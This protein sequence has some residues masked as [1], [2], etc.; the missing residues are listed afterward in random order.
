[1]QIKEEGAQ[2]SGEIEGN[3]TVKIY[4]P[5]AVGEKSRRNSTCVLH[6]KLQ[7]ISTPPRSL[8]ILWDQFHSIKYPPG[9]IPIDSF[10]V[11]ND[12][13]DWHGDHL[14][15]NFHS[16]FD[17]LRGAGYYIET[18][19]S[20]LTCFDANQYGTLL[21][22]DLEDEYFPEEI[23]KLRD[24]VINSGL[25]LAVFA[26]WYNLDAMVKMRFFDGNSHNW[27][28][29]VTG[30]ANVPALNDLLAT[31]GIAFGDK[32]LSGAFV[33]SSKQNRYASGT[34]ILEFP[35]GGYLHSFPFLD[36]LQSTATQ[37]V[38]LP[39]MAKVS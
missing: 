22:V 15:T 28:I 12:L 18:L 23:K 19:G 1:M 14:H 24:D 5:S 4:S 16:L 11:R 30:G 17:M 3:I 33:F 32:I 37:N 26:D 39:G 10:D 29:P 21:L 9:Y 25:G 2:F 13:L 20:P 36:R 6:L 34:D 38:V 27:W 31:F 8:R 7:V 35:R